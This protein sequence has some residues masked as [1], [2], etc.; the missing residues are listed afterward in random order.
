MGISLPKYRKR[1]WINLF[2][3]LLQ[4]VGAIIVCAYYGKYLDRAR[5]Q[6]KYADAKWVCNAHPKLCAIEHH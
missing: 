2:S 5:K 1:T 6:D 3:R 4:L